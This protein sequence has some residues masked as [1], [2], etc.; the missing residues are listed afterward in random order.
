MA[1]GV[2]SRLW[3]RSRKSTPKQFLDLTS[4]E[5]MLQETYRR[6]L[7]IIPPERMLV[8]TGIEYKDTV[9]RQ[10]PDLPPENLVLE[11]S[12][13]GTAP[14]IGLGA[15]HIHH[16]I[17]SRATGAAASEAVMAVVTADHYIRDAPLFRRI[18]LAAAATAQ[19]G[20]LVTLGITPSFPSTGYGY[21]QR[22]EL[23]QTLDGHPVYRAVRFTEKPDQ[24]TARTFVSSGLYSW[25]SGM[26]VWQV[27]SIR[28]EFERQMPELWAQLCEIEGALEAPDAQT[29][30]ERVWAG[31]A[32]E[33][34]DYGIMEGAFNVAVIPA[35]IGWNDIG[36]WQTLA[37][38][39]VH[40]D[41]LAD[42]EH[43]VVTRDHILLDTRNTL[44]HSPHKLVAAIGLRD[45]IVIE[46]D[47]AL[48]VCPRD[49]SQDVRKVVELLREQGREHLL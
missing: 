49:R 47:D 16:A 3:P 9:R 31:V 10:L 15:L 28:A 33:T 7:P 13:R 35:S 24:E 5:T 4:D 40:K 45:L 41:T 39:L 25:N 11:P 14:A 34:I 19:T 26:F 37:E 46:T 17:L 30:L 1:G 21:I 18:L 6:L 27:G 32:K 8:G 12:G 20:A 42:A 44:I 2:G 23:L 36:T 38:V 48:L 22:G 29:V 43:N